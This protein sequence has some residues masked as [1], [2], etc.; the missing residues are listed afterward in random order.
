MT[1][2]RQAPENARPPWYIATKDMLLFQ[3][4]LFLDWARDL[5]LAPVA[6]LALIAGLILRPRNPGFFLYKL[7][8][9]GRWSDRFIGLFNAG[10]LPGD[11]GSNP[12]EADISLDKLVDGLESALTNEMEKKGLAPDDALGTVDRAFATYADRLDRDTSRGAWR[13][14]RAVARLRK[15]IRD[16]QGPSTL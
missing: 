13:L 7:M 8:A 12:E 16:G 3:G 5:V 11:P 15:R 2:P 10:R 1:E 14:K 9:W 6:V 4:K